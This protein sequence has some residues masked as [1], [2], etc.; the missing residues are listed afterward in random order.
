MNGVE[1]RGYWPKEWP[2][3]PKDRSAQAAVA[4]LLALGLE[5]INLP[6]NLWKSRLKQADD[7]A[8]YCWYQMTEEEQEQASSLVGVWELNETKMQS[9]RYEEVKRGIDGIDHLLPRWEAAE[10]QAQSAQEEAA[11]LGLMVDQY[12]RIRVGRF[13]ILQEQFDRIGQHNSYEDYSDLREQWY[14][15]KPI[16]APLPRAWN[17]MLIICKAHETRERNATNWQGQGKHNIVSIGVTIAMG[18][19][20]I[21]E[22]RIPI[23]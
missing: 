6:S 13:H 19:I 5:I 14:S 18:V 11:Q 7:R 2:D 20:G 16:T 1:H 10:A 4:R 12:F 21:L 15:Q 8:E 23:L 9:I 17:R 3:W 22:E